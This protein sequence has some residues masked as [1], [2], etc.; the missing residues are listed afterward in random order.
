MNYSNASA[1]VAWAPCIARAIHSSGVLSRSGAVIVR[2][3]DGG[4]A[5]ASGLVPGDAV[6]SLNDDPVASVS[7]LDT[8]LSTLRAGAEVTVGVMLRSG[9][10]KVLTLSLVEV[11]NT[12][13]MNDAR[14][15]YN[16]VLL[17]M[18]DALQRATT[19]F[20]ETVARLNVGVTHIQ[21]GNWEQA[22]EAITQVQLEETNGVSIGTVDY[23]DRPVPRSRRTH[24]RRPVGLRARGPGAF[25]H[26]LCGWSSDL[27]TCRA[28]ARH[29][30]SELTDPS[31]NVQAVH[32]FT[33]GT[34]ERLS[35][36]AHIPPEPD[37]IGWEGSFKVV[38]SGVVIRGGHG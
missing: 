17:E 3:E 23:F 25:E 34:R 36:D 7:E 1:R 8:R 28:Q 21:L 38:R 12:I 37:P 31:H 19:P 4:A 5:A 16:K 22:Y 35:H 29:V 13:P 30:R 32:Y 20:E 33:S 11:P 15:V 27:P 10:A 18:E 9:E 24:G 6:V 14:V 26:A 2:V